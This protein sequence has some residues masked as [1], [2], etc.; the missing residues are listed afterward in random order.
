MS[1]ST[2]RA[3]PP[4][5]TLRGMKRTFIVLGLFLVVPALMGDVA[6]PGAGCGC[7]GGG[8]NGAEGEGE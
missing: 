8:G 7:G 6:P 1:L 5:G 3:A 2:S 4:G